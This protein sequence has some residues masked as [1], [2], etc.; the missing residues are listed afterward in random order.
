MSKEI[1]YYIVKV[2]GSWILVSDETFVAA[3]NFLRI[4][5]DNY[6]IISQQP[7]LTSLSEEDQKIIGF[8]DVEELAI[9]EFDTWDENKYLRSAFCKGFQLAQS[10]N[11]KKFSF[12]SIIDDMTNKIEELETEKENIQEQLDNAEKTIEDLKE[13]IEDLQKDIRSYQ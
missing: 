3:V 8:V 12:E 5:G 13:Q 1:K 7:I 6:K 9:Q 4:N 10:L 11:E 2:N